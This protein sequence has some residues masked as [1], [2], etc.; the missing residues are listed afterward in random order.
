MTDHERKE[1]EHRLDNIL[2]AAEEKISELQSEIDR[3]KPVYEIVGQ[4]V[5]A[6][7]A[8][9]D[10]LPSGEQEIIKVYRK[11]EKQRGNTNDKRTN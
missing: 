8:H 3:M 11:A 10:V 2:Q 7:G 9:F 6:W 5:A 4:M 1:L